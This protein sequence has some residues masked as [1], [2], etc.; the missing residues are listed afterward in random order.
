MIYQGWMVEL[1]VHDPVTY[2]AFFEEDRRLARPSLQQMCSEGIILKEDPLA[3]QIKEEA[4]RSLDSGPIPWT[5]NEIYVK[6]YDLTDLLL[7]FEGTEK[8]EE[9]IFIAG[10]LAKATQEFILRTNGQWIGYKKWIPQALQRYDSDLKTEF[11]SAFDTYFKED[12]KTAVIH[13]IDKILKPF[14]GR[15]FDGFTQGKGTILGILW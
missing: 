5:E 11:I 4:R 12:K 6:R 9:G 8:R 3:Y 1:F 15:L 10:A 13:L 2:K 7:D 14:G